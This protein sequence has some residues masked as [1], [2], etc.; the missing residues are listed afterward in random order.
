VWQTKKCP[1]F[2]GTV[3][4]QK[5]VCRAGPHTVTVR[6]LR[7]ESSKPANWKLRYMSRSVN[8][9]P[10]PT[11]MHAHARHEASF[12]SIEVQRTGFR[13]LQPDYGGVGEG[14]QYGLRTNRTRIVDHAVTMRGGALTI[15]LYTRI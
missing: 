6:A 3:R 8:W 5:C 7:I 14:L 1:R 12:E 9:T 15:K 4:H 11:Q 13:I 2:R 10:S